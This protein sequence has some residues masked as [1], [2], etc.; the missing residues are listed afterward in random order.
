M[1]KSPITTIGKENLLSH[2]MYSKLYTVKTRLNGHLSY[3][4][5]FVGGSIGLMKR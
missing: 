1:S 4:A 3:V 2:L 5:T